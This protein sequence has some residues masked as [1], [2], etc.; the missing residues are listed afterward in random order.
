MNLLLE[1]LKTNEMT[2]NDMKTQ[3]IRK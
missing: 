1:F 3:K 2:T